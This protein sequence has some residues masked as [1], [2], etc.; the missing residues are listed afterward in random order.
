MPSFLDGVDLSSDGEDSSDDEGVDDRPFIYRSSSSRLLTDYKGFEDGEEDSE[1]PLASQMQA[2]LSLQ[3]ALGLDKDVGFLAAQERQKAEKARLAQLTPEERLAEAD[4]ETNDMLSQVKQRHL[5]RSQA[6]REQQEQEEKKAK[7]RKDQESDAQDL[8][9]AQEIALLQ[10]M[11]AEKEEA[12]LAAMREAPDS[13]EDSPPLLPIADLEIE[14]KERPAHETPPNDNVDE[15]EA[16][17]AKQ[18][19]DD[20]GLYA[21]PSP[22]ELARTLHDEPIFHDDVDE[23]G[24]FIGDANVEKTEEDFRFRPP[25]SQQRQV[26]DDEASFGEESDDNV[27]NDD[28]SGS[29]D[30]DDGILTGDFEFDKPVSEEKKSRN[31][32]KLQNLIQHHISEGAYFREN[33]TEHGAATFE[34][35]NE[36]EPRTRSPIAPKA[37]LSESPKA[38]IKNRIAKPGNSPMSPKRKKG[39]LSTSVSEPVSPE[40][41]WSKDK[42]SPQK[43]PGKT[44][45]VTV[46]P[47]LAKGGAESSKAASSCLSPK[48]KPRAQSVNALTK[49]KDSAASSWVA[50]QRAQLEAASQDEVKGSVSKETVDLSPTQ[51]TK[52]RVMGDAAQTNLVNLKRSGRGRNTDTA[53]TPAA[54]QSPTNKAKAQSPKSTKRSS[55]SPAKGA[56]EKVPGSPKRLIRQRKIIKKK[57]GSKEIVV[58]ILDPVT[59][60]EIKQESVE[61]VPPSGNEATG[62]QVQAFAG[63]SP[64]QSPKHASKD[65]VA[66]QTK[67]ASKTDAGKGRGPEAATK[68][69]SRSLEQSTEKQDSPKK[70]ESPLKAAGTAAKS[71]V[72][73][74]KINMEISTVPDLEKKSKKRSK[75]DKKRKSADKEKDKSSKKKGSGKETKSEKKDKVSTDGA[76]KKSKKKDKVSADGAEK[77]STKSKKK[78]DDIP[79]AE[80]KDKKA[81][82][83][84]KFGKDPS[85]T[86]SGDKKAKKTKKKADKAATVVMVETE[87]EKRS[88]KKS[89]KDDKIDKPKKE[90]KTEKKEATDTHVKGSKDKSGKDKKNKSKSKSTDENTNTAN[91]SKSKSKDLKSKKSS[92]KEAV[93]GIKTLEMAAPD[94][95]VT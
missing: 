60:N 10:Q 73:D 59:M 72:V 9:A 35:E 24:H 76:K 66:G 30:T 49:S 52:K 79:A 81:K 12:L 45:R 15:E 23:S 53:S 28:D 50:K 94:R 22:E 17:S 58:S 2:V 33:E 4:V 29:G 89:G 80:S 63:I 77:K 34:G 61:R 90:S 83:S 41:K 71:A 47:W 13:Q 84:K 26:S 1:N 44:G 86:E 87:K 8:A 74:P 37:K 51:K 95:M 92:K 64:A 5:A 67:V 14:R 69:T 36:A 56:K 42:V 40:L 20:L 21:F 38:K 85:A 18:T 27:F 48:S 91:A 75:K 70:I 62:S 25:A 65:G 16:P 31:R 43:S 78:D 11:R 68:K 46:P 7:T 19:N 82:K 3:I 57:D 54:P 55:E 88:K 32:A 93:D 39:S 6:Q